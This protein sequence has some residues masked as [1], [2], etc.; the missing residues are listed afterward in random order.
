MCA[1]FLNA[2]YFTS[3]QTQHYEYER[4]KAERDAIDEARLSRSRT[5]GGAWRR[6]WDN[7]KVDQGWVLEEGRVHGRGSALTFS[8]VKMKTTE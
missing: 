4:W 5:N 2:L 6:E 1:I 8:V 3:I 7:D